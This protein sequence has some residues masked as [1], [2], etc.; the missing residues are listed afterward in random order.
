VLL[1]GAYQFDPAVTTP[2]QTSLLAGVIFLLGGL[3]YLVVWG[4]CLY[5]A[6]R[7]GSC[8][9][10]LADL[11]LGLFAATLQALFGPVERPRHEAGA[12]EVVI[13]THDRR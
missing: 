10:I 11:L 6:I 7:T 8:L 12:T 5:W 1:W 4:Y 13:P 3:L 9:W 2:Q